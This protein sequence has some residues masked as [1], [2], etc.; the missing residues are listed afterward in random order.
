MPIRSSSR[1]QMWHVWM[2]GRCKESTAEVLLL[3]SSYLSD[4]ITVI[5]IT[6]QLHAALQPYQRVSKPFR[7]KACVRA[8]A[9]DAV[10]KVVDTRSQAKSFVL[11]RD[12][13]GRPR[14][15][16]SALYAE[17]EAQATA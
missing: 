9:H 14:F 8:R 4:P 15:D 10:G 1:V 11:E 7:R 2:L 13:L 12:G 5:H 6:T 16:S 3:K 17:Q